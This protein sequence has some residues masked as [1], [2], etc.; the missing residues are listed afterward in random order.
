MPVRSVVYMIMM[1][2]ICESSVT[3]T[4]AVTVT[5]T[6]RRLKGLCTK[7]GLRFRLKVLDSAL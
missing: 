7:A 6:R 2:A 4:V 5:M 3:V 1:S